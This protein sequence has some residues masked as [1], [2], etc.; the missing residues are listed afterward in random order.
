MDDIEE[1]QDDLEET[2]IEEEDD[3]DNFIDNSDDDIDEDEDEVSYISST[4]ISND[5][6]YIKNDITKIKTSPYITKFEYTKLLSIRT[7]MIA[8]GSPI[9]I[10]L[11]EKISDP[12]QIALLEYKNNKCPLLVRRYYPNG[13]Y[14]DI[15]NQDLINKF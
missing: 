8:R 3:I 1:I 6:S 2:Y 12:Y 13:K 15:K 11:T 9:L 10:E 5:E 7:Q 4:I 14:E